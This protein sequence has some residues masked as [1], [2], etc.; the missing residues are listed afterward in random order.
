[1]IGN[2]DQLTQSLANIVGIDHVSTDLFERINY[3]DTSLP[4]DVEEREI[5]LTL[6]FIPGIRKR[7]PK[8]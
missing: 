4:Y 1:M 6:S 5:Y 3:A 8:C 2:L 7:L